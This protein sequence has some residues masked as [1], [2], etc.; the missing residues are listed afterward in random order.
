[1]RDI[2]AEINEFKVPIIVIDE[3]LGKFKHQNR[4][5]NKLKRMNELLTKVGVPE[6]LLE[7]DNSTERQV[8]EKQSSKVEE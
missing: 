2:I 5:E 1:M 8:I 4:F 6:A 7:D 3:S